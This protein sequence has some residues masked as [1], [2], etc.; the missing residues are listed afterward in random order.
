MLTTDA[1]QFL[2]RN[3]SSV[4]QLEI[5]LLLFADPQRRW[6][7]DELTEELRSSVA[8]VQRRLSDLQR[9]RLVA[10]DER[11]SYGYRPD[12]RNDGRVAEIR[13][14]YRVRP[15]RIVDMIFAEP[16]AALSS[17]SDA[18]RLKGG[19]DDDR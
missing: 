1:R 9:R 7:A 14:E 11:A 16:G 8:S 12:P 19:D 10:W 18:F 5:L 15:G 13:D 6:T 2:S 17:F 3:I 4:E